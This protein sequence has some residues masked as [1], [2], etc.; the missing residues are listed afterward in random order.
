LLVV[1]V[2]LVAF[3]VDRA[4]LSG[5]T[6]RLSWP[7]KP[8]VWKGVEARCGTFVVLENRAKPNGRKIGLHV[9]VLP[10]LSEANPRLAVAFLAGGPG[11]AATEEALDEG[12]QSSSLH[13]FRDL[14]LV[15]QRGTGGSRPPHGADVTQ[16]GTRMAMDDLDAVRAA[17]GYRKLDV[18]GGS[19][20][21]TAAQVYLRLHPSSV[22]TLTIGGAS[23]LDV[24]FFARYAVNAQSALDQWAKLCAS[25]PD[26]RKAFPNWERQF[27]ALVK[28]WD[29]HPVHGMTGVE[30][31]AVV[32]AM[33]RNMDTAV[34]IPFVV[35]RA[36]RGDT[37]PLKRA[38]P[39]D[40]GVHLDIMGASI[41]CNEPWTGLNASGPWGTDFDSSTT[42]FIADFRMACRS[43]PRRT[44]PPT[45]WK[46]PT[47]SRVPVLAYVGSADSQ[48][49]ATNLP[50]LRQHFPDS[51]IVVLPYQGHETTG[52]GDC[53]NTWLANFVSRGTTKGL[54]TSCNATSVAVAPFPLPG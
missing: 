47:A 45:F 29:A 26:C 15:D 34:S 18:L 10:A 36:V 44:E 39:G 30:L 13:S 9:V 28:A 17:L 12:W 46:L 4:F 23:A 33:L 3:G 21:A 6:M 8:C 20:G 1:A 41:W 43:V 40:L 25:Q 14:L 11:S 42:A 5:Q 16:Y 31:A 19:Y 49:P 7:P 48:D 35:S 2:G 53:F 50:D 27:G 22:R 52:L 32:H 24:P 38:G 51:R 54:D 37:G